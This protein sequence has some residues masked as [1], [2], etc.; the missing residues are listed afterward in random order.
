MCSEICKLMM[1]HLTNPDTLLSPMSRLYRVKVL[2]SLRI[3]A[4]YSLDI[5]S[6]PNNAY[7]CLTLHLRL[8]MT[9]KHTLRFILSIS[10][11]NSI[12]VIFLLQSVLGFFPKRCSGLFVLS[13]DNSFL[14][15]FLCKI[16][17]HVA[18]L[19]FCC[20]F[21]VRP[22]RLTAFTPTARNSFCMDNSTIFLLCHT[23]VATFC[24]P[25]EKEC[26]RLLFV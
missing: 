3:L 22:F 25:C 12:A 15:P 16:I 10:S 1:I 7:Q 17:S 6:V 5:G 14:F 26:R 8:F 11:K 24:F 21:I 18:F 4:L 2:V 13:P 20:W 23:I 9:Q 19:F